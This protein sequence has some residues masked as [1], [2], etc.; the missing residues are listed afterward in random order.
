MTHPDHPV[1]SSAYMTGYRTALLD[2]QKMA[3]AR[4]HKAMQE[5]RTEVANA[6]AELSTD[7]LIEREALTPKEKT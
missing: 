7:L 3:N 1:A 2:A 6:M 4:S 5:G